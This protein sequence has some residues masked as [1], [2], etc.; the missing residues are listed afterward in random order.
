MPLCSD[1]GLEFLFEFIQLLFLFILHGLLLK[2]SNVV[3]LLLGYAE[4][5]G[6]KYLLVVF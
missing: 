5:F 3:D 4:F 6:K 1:V 2:L